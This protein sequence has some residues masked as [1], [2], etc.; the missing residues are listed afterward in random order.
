M[1]ISSI[2]PLK[3]TKIQIINL[4]KMPISPIIPLKETNTNNKSADTVYHI[5]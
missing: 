1:L 4:P 3:E 2:I 5:G